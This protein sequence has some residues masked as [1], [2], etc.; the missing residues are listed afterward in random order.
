[1]TRLELLP[2]GPMTLTPSP[3]EARALPELDSLLL[4][5]MLLLP[6]PTLPLLPPARPLLRTLVTS[7]M[8][9]GVARRRLTLVTLLP[10]LWT[11][12]ILRPSRPTSPRVTTSPPT[13]P[14]AR[15][16]CKFWDS[17]KESRGTLTYTVV[18]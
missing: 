13:W 9:A 14:A 6:R 8:L 11:P 17:F 10:P 1:M 15:L 7:W 18:V 16:A 12:T 5:P 3:T 2:R 4:L